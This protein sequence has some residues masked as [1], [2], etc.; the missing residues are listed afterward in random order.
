VFFGL[1]LLV[2]GYL[3][4]RTVAFPRALGV[5]LAVASVCYL[6]NSVAVLMALDYGGTGQALVLLPAAVAE[7]ALCGWLIRGR[8][9]ARISATDDG[10]VPQ[11]R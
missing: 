11:A 2:L 10:R 9:P 6:A 7:L 4:L 3:M 5:L 1:H 8:L